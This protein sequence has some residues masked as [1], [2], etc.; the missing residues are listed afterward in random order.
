[1]CCVL[2]D[3]PASPAG[4]TAEMTI[5]RA[6]RPLLETTLHIHPYASHGSLSYAWKPGTSQ[7]QAPRGISFFLREKLPGERRPWSPGA[8]DGAPASMGARGTNKRNLP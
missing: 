2:T 1:M 6:G 3:L 7:R 5:A 8:L 4:G